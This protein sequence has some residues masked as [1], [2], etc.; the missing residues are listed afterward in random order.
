ML[1]HPTSPAVSESLQTSPNPELKHL[2]SLGHRRHFRKGEHIFRSGSPGKNVYILEHGRA[3]VYKLS[4]SGKEVI[5]WFC[6]PCEMFGLSEISQG[7]QRSVYAQACMDSLIHC[8]E[9]DDF[10]RFLANNAEHAMGVIDILSR[11]LRLLS[12]QFMNLAADGLRC[13]IIKLILRMSGQAQDED[14]VLTH[15]EIADMVG[16]SRQS[17]TSILNEIKRE[18]VL[19]IEHRRI[20]IEDPQRLAAMAEEA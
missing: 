9:R 16:S 20:H 1:P 10:N 11:R 19:R 13:R 18:G 2:L 4:D 5:L 3:K 6:H 14:I 7:G 17:V 15:Q 8:I 12:D